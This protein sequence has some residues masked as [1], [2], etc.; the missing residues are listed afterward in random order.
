[1]NVKLF[2][3]NNMSKIPIFLESYFYFVNAF[4]LEG[5]K[6]IDFQSKFSIS[7]GV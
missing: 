1:M 2:L 3:K 6:I 7:L 4:R 5:T